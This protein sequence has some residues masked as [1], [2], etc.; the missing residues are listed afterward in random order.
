M[1]KTDEKYVNKSVDIDEM[2]K[3]GGRIVYNARGGRAVLL[4]KVL[5]SDIKDEHE[6]TELIRRMKHEDIALCCVHDEAAAGI[7]AGEMGYGS[8]KRCSQWVCRMPYGNGFI[9]E[10]IRALGSDQLEY[11]A[12][13]SGES[14]EYLADRIAA[15][16]L[17]GLF[18]EEKPAGFIGMHTAGSIGMLQVLP[19]YRRRGIGEKLERYAIDRQISL[20]FVPYMHVVDE[21]AASLALQQKIG[22]VRCLNPALWLYQG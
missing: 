12:E 11:T 10:D 9:G 6:L 21:N 13:Y 20:G 14:R 4:D 19:E 3:H 2:I 16:C 22:A 1:K 18:I 7:I 8:I 17:W 15:G 5:L